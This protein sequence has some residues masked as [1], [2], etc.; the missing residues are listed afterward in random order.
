M[1][2]KI[3]KSPRQKIFVK[4]KILES[5]L[6]EF[7][8]NS[9]SYTVYIFE[10]FFGILCYYHINHTILTLFYFIDKYANVHFISF[11]FFCKI[12]HLVHLPFFELARIWIL[13]S[14]FSRL[15]KSSVYSIIEIRRWCHKLQVYTLCHLWNFYSE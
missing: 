1:D 13:F 2:K 3:V 12:L 11:F 8:S 5:L 7:E 4:S 10:Y 6:D 9:K 14:L 15:S